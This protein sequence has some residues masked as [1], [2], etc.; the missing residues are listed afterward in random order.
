VE[1]ISTSILDNA[2]VLFYTLVNKKGAYMR[3][4]IKCA[5]FTRLATI[6]SF[7]EPE[8]A[9]EDRDVI[10]TVRL[11]AI[12]GKLIAV[13]TNMRIAAIE[14]IGTVPV[15]QNG[16]AHIV[17]DPSL[18]AQCKA[19]SFIDGVL[20]IN[21]IPEIAVASAQT[22]SG[23]SMQGNTCHWYEDTPLNDWRTWA[24]DAP[25]TKSEGI[26]MWGLYAVQSLAESS[27]T[28]KVI[29]PRYIDAMKPVV[30]RDKTNPNWVGLF[31]PR[32][33]NDQQ[34]TEATLPEWWNK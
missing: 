20:T 15:G 18:I 26:M 2:Q 21:T 30:L 4:D 34:K 3:F 13:V 25:I 22:S 29:F 24:P 31:V 1:I 17:L 11:E 28:G 12:N 33:Y 7:F 10:N 27:P 19:E 14:L 16:V 23:W 9:K 5:T 32:P 6:C 8:C